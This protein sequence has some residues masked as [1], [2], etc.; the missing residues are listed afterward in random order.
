M[1]TT[2]YKFSLQDISTYRKALMGVAMLWIVFYHFGFHTPIISH[3]TR[4]GYTG[5]DIFMFLS[6][7]GLFY[8]LQKKQ[9]LSNY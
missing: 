8:S 4:F 9:G 1:E 5:V 3:L 7:F 6:G 2:D